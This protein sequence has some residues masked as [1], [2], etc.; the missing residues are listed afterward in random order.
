MFTLTGQKLGLFKGEG[1]QLLFYK[2]CPHV[3]C[4]VKDLKCDMYYTILVIPVL[5]TCI[6]VKL[7]KCVLVLYY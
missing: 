3:E 2:W 6:E 4:P 1:V 5:S 7:S